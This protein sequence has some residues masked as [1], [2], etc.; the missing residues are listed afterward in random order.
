[1]QSTNMGFGL[2]GMPSMEQNIYR[3]QNF[4]EVT[5]ESGESPFQEVIFYKMTP[6]G[7]KMQGTT[8]EEMIRVSI[9]RL[10]D[11]N[12]RFSCRENSVAITKL[13][14]ALMWLNKRTE[15][16]IARGIEGKHLVYNN[17]LTMTSTD[18]N[19]ISVLHRS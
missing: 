12:N 3:L 4:L 13:E 8:L 2:Q 14:E 1:M 11:L 17:N 10:S 15:N 5:E 7:R 9:E 19:S 16:R 18:H 6:D